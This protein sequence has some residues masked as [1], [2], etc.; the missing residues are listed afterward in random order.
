MVCVLLTALLWLQLLSLIAILRTVF[1]PIKPIDLIDE[2][3]ARLRMELDSKPEEIDE[4]DRRI[5]QLKIER[6]A[7]RRETDCCLSRTIWQ[8]RS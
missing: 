8:V 7:L 2:S 5:I 1:C 4:L 3:A 6:E